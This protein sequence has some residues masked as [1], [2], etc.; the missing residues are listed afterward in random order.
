MDEC[1]AILEALIKKTPDYLDAYYALG[2][3]YGKNNND[4]KAHYYIGR[5]YYEIDNPRNALFHLQKAHELTSDPEIKKELEEKIKD[6]KKEGRR[7]SKTAD[8]DSCPPALSCRCNTPY[9]LLDAFH[10]PSSDLREAIVKMK[11]SNLTHTR[12]E[13]L[14]KHVDR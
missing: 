9:R 3:A 13:P 10:S 14:C 6:M 7:P 12:K 8:P 2:M 1:I 4:A 11:T 5:Y